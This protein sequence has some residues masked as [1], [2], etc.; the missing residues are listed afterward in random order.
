M[1]RVNQVGDE[2]RLRVALG[3]SNVPPG[4]LFEDG[5]GSSAG[6]LAGVEQGFAQGATGV[7]VRV[8]VSTVARRRRP[9]TRVAWRGVH[10]NRAAL[11]NKVN[12][13]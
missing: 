1:G 2:Q 3:L 13:H 8:H 5:R 9:R 7:V 12:A 11:L 6:P 4:E 10:T